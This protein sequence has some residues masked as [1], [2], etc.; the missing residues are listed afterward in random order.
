MSEPPVY[1]FRRREKTDFEPLIIT[2]DYAFCVIKKEHCRISG[3]SFAEYVN[4]PRLYVDG[5]DLIC[6]GQRIDIRQIMTRL[7]T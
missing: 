6:V 2:L 1:I 4:L 3:V 5:V 7:I